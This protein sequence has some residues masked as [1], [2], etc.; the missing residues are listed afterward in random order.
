VTGGEPFIYITGRAE[1]GPQPENERDYMSA[2][3]DE[4]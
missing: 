2:L 1:V 4:T 3:L